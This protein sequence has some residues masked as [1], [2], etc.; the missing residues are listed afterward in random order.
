M[1]NAQADK[2]FKE[3]GRRIAAHR[4]A[5]SMSQDKLAYESGLDRSHVGFIEQGRRH[6][7][8]PTLL[9]IGKV[10]DLSLEQLFKNF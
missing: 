9:R 5:K 10:L 8:V 7:T 6:P 1:S 2:V 3:V 4:N